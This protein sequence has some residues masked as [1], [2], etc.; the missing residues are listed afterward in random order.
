MF[1]SGSSG[2]RQGFLDHLSESRSSLFLRK[3]GLRPPHSPGRHAVPRSSDRGNDA[4]AC[5]SKGP[6]RLPPQ[7]YVLITR[8]L[9]FHGNGRIRDFSLKTITNTGYLA[10]KAV[11]TPV[12]STRRGDGASPRHRPAAATRPS[13]SPAPPPRP[14]TLRQLHKGRTAP[15]V[16]TRASL[17][18]QLGFQ[19][20]YPAWMC[21]EMEVPD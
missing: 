11:S 16:F 14:A 9:Y 19:R 5:G 10:V 3:A 13:R 6:E 7:P 12:S 18:S 15:S 8:S 1:L 4:R 20:A 17:S 2:T 21:W